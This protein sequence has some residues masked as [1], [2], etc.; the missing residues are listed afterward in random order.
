MMI[1]SKANPLVKHVRSLKEKKFR[2]DFGEFIVE[3]EKMVR[4]SL[5]SS[6][7]RMVTIVSA[8]YRGG[9]FS[10]PVL[11]VSDEVFAF[12]SDEKT[13]QG[14]LSVLKI[15]SLAPLPCDEPCLLLDGISDPGNMGTILRTA[16]A[17]GYKRIY[18]ADCTDPFSPKSVRASMSGIFFVELCVGTR[19]EIVKTVNLPIIAA[20][21]GGEDVFSFCPPKA[22][23]LAIGNEANGLS[24]FVREQ[25]SHV[26]AIPMEST[27]ESLNAAV[28]AGILMY[29]LKHNYQRR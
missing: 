19:E 21:M 22:Y 29:T 24:S 11:V 20:D 15:P 10:L 14:I 8:S 9:T 3:G 13:P 2:K 25:A 23:I 1:T 7:E 16:N 17:A 4:E 28:S 26:V 12:L 27:Q 18:L 6:L 5:S